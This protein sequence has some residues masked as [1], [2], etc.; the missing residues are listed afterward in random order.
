MQRHYSNEKGV[1]AILLTT[2]HKGPK[3]NIPDLTV[4]AVTAPT[5]GYCT[6]SAPTNAPTNA[7]SCSPNLTSYILSSA[8]ILT[9]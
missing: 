6:I 4:S 5:Y 3:Y 2:T 9:L 7:P 1:L 8:Q